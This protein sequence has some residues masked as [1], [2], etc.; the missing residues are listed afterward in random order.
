MVGTYHLLY[1]GFLSLSLS[2][3]AKLR[4]LASK[5]W[6]RMLGGLSLKVSWQAQSSQPLS[7][8]LA[9]KAS[10]KVFEILRAQ[11]SFF[12]PGNF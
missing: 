1:R 9:R 12:L 8:V 11:L 2:L 4:E 3:G 6:R 7:E 10:Q 5:I